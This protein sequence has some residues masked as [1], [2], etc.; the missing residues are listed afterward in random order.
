MKNTLFLTNIL[1][2]FSISNSIAQTKNDYGTV[3]YKQVIVNDTVINDVIET[4][5]VLY[6]NAVQKKSVYHWDRKNK[7][8]KRE[9]QKT[10]DGSVKVVRPNGNSGTDSVGRVVYSEYNNNVLKIRDRSQQ[11]YI[12][13]D[14]ISIQWIIANETKILN[15]MNLQKATGYFRG[16]LYTAWFNPNIPI[17]DGPWKLKGLPGLIMEAYDEKKH[18]RFDFVALTLPVNFEEK[19]QVPTDGTPINFSVYHEKHLNSMGDAM[20]RAEA[21]LKQSGIT[22]Q[23]GTL[24]T[25]TIERSN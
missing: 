9:I 8:Y 7:N 19:I 1:T 11:W 23:G 20:K 6:F 25:N 15:N 16:R 24:R 21:K 4:K 22:L 12:I 10:E 3:E 17:P 14:T 5:G 2:L 18:V 13:S